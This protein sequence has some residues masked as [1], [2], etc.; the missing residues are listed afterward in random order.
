MPASINFKSEVVS[1]RKAE[2]RG[3]QQ[4]FKSERYIRLTRFYRINWKRWTC[5]TFHFVNRCR[6]SIMGESSE[7][8][9]YCAAT[10]HLDSF[11]FSISKC[12]VL[13]P[14]FVGSRQDIYLH[15]SIVSYSSFRK[16]RW[17]PKVEE[18][19]HSMF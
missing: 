13:P 9:L 19:T 17:A 6:M 18:Y 1:R 14:N 7:S 10:G 4:S 12:N 3:E 2:K 11:H 15:P 16:R 5:A 8:I